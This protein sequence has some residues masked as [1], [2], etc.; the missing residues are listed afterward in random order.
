ME[1]ITISKITRYSKN[2][3][4][5]ELVTRD[6]KPYV[7]V[8]IECDEH[9]GKKISGFGSIGNAQW[10]AGDKVQ[11]EIEQKGEYLNFKTP[12]ASGGSSFTEADRNTLIRI[13]STLQQVLNGMKVLANVPDDYPTNDL[14]EPPF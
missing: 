2:S 10:K 7:R 14:G 3:D 13:E 11:V 8:V 1:T 4:G 5:D 12:K 9:K 6:G